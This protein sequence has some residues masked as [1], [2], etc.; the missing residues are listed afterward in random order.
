[1][2]SSKNIGLHWKCKELSIGFIVPA[3]IKISKN[4]KILLIVIGKNDAYVKIMEFLSLKYGM[5]KNLK[6]LFQKGY[7][8]L[9]NSLI[10]YPKVLINSLILIHCFYVLV[11]F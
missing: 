4:L 1:M 7:E 6:S 10:R 11:N 2:P 8:K 3:G 9:R 5:T